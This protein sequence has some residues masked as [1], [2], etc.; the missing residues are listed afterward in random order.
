MGAH[1]NKILQTS[2]E[3]AED[4]YSKLD[5]HLN[6]LDTHKKGLTD[7]LQNAS[8]SIATSRMDMI[9]K[10]RQS[11]LGHLGRYNS[12]DP[13]NH[14]TGPHDEFAKSDARDAVI[15]PSKGEG[16]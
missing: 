13:R 3:T 14:G 7:R 1:H 12:S 9:A 15:P 5:K 2:V 8:T 16:G 11:V 6:V 10:Q 4:S